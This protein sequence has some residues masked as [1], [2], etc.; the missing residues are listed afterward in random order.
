MLFEN[1]VKVNVYACVNEMFEIL[2]PT[3]EVLNE[4]WTVF[5]AAVDTYWK[6]F[7]A[8]KEEKN[9]LSMFHDFISLQLI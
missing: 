1:R 6:E 5:T 4:E 2:S 7:I 8:K 3:L 9:F